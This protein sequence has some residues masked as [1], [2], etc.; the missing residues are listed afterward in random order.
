MEEMRDQIVIRHTEN[1]MANSILFGLNSQSKDIDW[2]NVLK[3]KKT[4]SQLYTA[5]K[6]FT[7]DLRTRRG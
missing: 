4:V 1:K 5:C 2:Q 6:T 7:L 3:N